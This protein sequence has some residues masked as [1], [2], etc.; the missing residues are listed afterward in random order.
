[1]KKEKLK[2]LILESLKD[3]EPDRKILKDLQD[4]VLSF[5]FSDDF[6][7]KVTERI[8]SS[9]VV[10]HKEEDFILS[11]SKIFYRIAF[12]GIAAIILLLISIYI[13][14]GNLSI[15]SFL[16]LGDIADES[17]LFALTGN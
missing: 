11:A 7:D 2:E 14:Q 12:T 16:G 15:D 4:A 1:M 10:I 13:S 8:Y 3:E 5:S 17:I 6:A 9:A